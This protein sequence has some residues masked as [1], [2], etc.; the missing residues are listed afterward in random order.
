MARNVLE[1]LSKYEDIPSPGEPTQIC[2]M[3]S[4]PAPK[5]IKCEKLYLRCNFLGFYYIET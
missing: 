1:G 4:N 3:D 5:A 2:K